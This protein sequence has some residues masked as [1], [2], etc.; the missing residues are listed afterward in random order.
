LGL[1]VSRSKIKSD[2]RVLQIVYAG[3]FAAPGE[4]K[5]ALKAARAAGFGDAILR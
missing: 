1:P 2:G 4:A 3:P 5:A